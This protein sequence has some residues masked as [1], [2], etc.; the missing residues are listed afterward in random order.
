M[1]NLGQFYL[2][3]F[4]NYSELFNVDYINSTIK[5]DDYQSNIFILKFN[6]VQ[7]K[8]HSHEHEIVKEMSS[9]DRWRGVGHHR[10]SKRQSFDVSS[11]QALL[12]FTV[13]VQ[14]QLTSKALHAAL[15]CFCFL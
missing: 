1:F 12:L 8:A 2:V 4:L 9:D 5:R 13:V 14:F 15:Q 11:D 7:I 10:C 3:V 6:S